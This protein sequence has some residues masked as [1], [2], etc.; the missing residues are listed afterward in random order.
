MT[1][2]W[3][4]GGMAIFLFIIFVVILIDMIYGRQ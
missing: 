2:N 4:L 1:G 3:I